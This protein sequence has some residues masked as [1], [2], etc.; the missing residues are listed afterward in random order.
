MRF[1]LAVSLVLFLAAVAG[2][3]VA[4]DRTIDDF[5]TGPFKQT[6]VRCGKVAPSSQNG[7]ML[8]GNRSTGLLLSPANACGFSQ[9]NSYEFKLATKATPPAFLF[10]AGYGAGPR[11][12]MG[13]GF[14]APMNIDFTP[15]DRIRV[16]FLGLTQPLNFNILVFTGTTWAQN[17][18]NISELNRPFSIEL[19]LNGFIISGPS[20]SW[21]NINFIDNIF[22]SGS[23]IGGVDLAVS[24]IQ[25][26]NTPMPGAQIC[27][28]Q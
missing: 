16:N 19:P 11:I 28:L 13:Y 12:D 5:T 15:Y 25:L 22:Q 7:A 10:N 24:S 4:Q 18:C 23:A 9:P 21:S 6:P 3:A 2:S 27:R 20:F 26:S 17:G 8:G 1:K 14:G